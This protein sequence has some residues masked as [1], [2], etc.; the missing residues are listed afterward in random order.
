MVCV[1][2]DA[3]PVT[4]E[5]ASNREEVMMQFSLRVV[6]RKSLLRDGALKTT[7]IQDNASLLVSVIVARSVKK[8]RTDGV[9]ALSRYFGTLTHTTIY[10]A[11]MTS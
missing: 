11:T 5:R 8:E 10:R 9:A 6:A 2:Q 3:V 4:V 1:N 7:I